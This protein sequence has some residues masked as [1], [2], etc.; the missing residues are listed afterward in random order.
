M[1]RGYTDR[2][3]AA[4]PQATACP[5]PRV[6]NVLIFFFLTHALLPLGQRNRDPRDVLQSVG[7]GSNHMIGRS[8]P[9]LG[10][11]ELFHEQNVT[12]TRNV[13]DTEQNKMQ[14]QQAMMLMTTTTTAR[15]NICLLGASRFETP[16]PQVSSIFPSQGLR[17]GT[18]S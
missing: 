3:V 8:G 4:S 10:L 1:P 14:P 7:G 2:V 6:S 15:L 11:N 17:S 13:N 12:S 18:D 16:L 9:C 5:R